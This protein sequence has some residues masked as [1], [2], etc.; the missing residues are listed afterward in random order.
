VNG[1]VRRFGVSGLLYR[2]N[3]TMFDRETNSLWN[4]MLLGSQCGL[5]RGE[6]LSRLPI[7]E[8]TW[9]Q[10]VTAHPTTTVL[11]VDQSD[12]FVGYFVYPY[13][14]YD[15]PNNGAVDFVAPGVTWRDDRPPKELVLG[16]F[17]GDAALAFPFGLMAEVDVIND[18]IAGVPILVTFEKQFELATVFERRV[19]GEELTFR[20]NPDQPF[21]FTDD[22]TSSIWNS[23][24]VATAGPR[25]STRLGRYAD[26]YV[27]FW[28][29]WSLYYPDIEI[30][31]RP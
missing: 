26:S 23:N 29:A 14:A 28:F 24:G 19:D 20:V 18:Q 4:Q 12:D 13:G 16:V 17:K 31:S 3:L 30:F 5:E 22:Q 11:S 25:D 6:I 8:T 21:T 7:T 27:A 2:S 10:W 15:D 1:T 9:G